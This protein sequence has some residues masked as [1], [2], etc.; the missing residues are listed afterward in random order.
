MWARST[1][2]RL[3][4]WSASPSPWL[5]RGGAAGSDVTLGAVACALLRLMGTCMAFGGACPNTLAAI[6]RRMSSPR[7]SFSSANSAARRSTFSSSRT[8]PGQW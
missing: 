6:I 8:L 2:A 1:S 3:V 7:I 5:A 4:R